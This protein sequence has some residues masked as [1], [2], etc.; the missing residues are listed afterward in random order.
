MDEKLKEEIAASGIKLR[1]RNEP[2][3]IKSVIDVIDAQ[4]GKEYEVTSEVLRTM[5]YGI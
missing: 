5:L 2:Q 3:T 1:A 4:E